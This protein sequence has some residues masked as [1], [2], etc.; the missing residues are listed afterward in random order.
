MNIVATICSLM[1]FLVLAISY[2]SVDDNE[3]SDKRVKCAL[4]IVLLMQTYVAIS[5]LA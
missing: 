3:N 4:F 5:T 2:V 1:V